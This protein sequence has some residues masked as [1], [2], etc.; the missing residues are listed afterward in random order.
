[1][2][3][4]V[5]GYCFAHLTHLP[6][7]R[8]ALANHC[9]A[10]NLKGTILLSPEGINV[11]LAGPRTG[12]ESAMDLIRSYPGLESFVG[13]ESFSETQP[14]RRMLVRLK[15]E[16][17]SFGVEKANPLHHE[18]PRLSPKDLKRWLDEGKELIL[19]DTRNDYEVELGTFQNAEHFDLKSFRA[20]IPAVEEKRTTWKHK[21]VV[22]FCTGGIRCEKAAPFMKMLGYE[23]VYQLEGGILK[24]FEEV[25]G[26]HWNGDCFVFDQRVAL[27]PELKPSGHGLCF[28][29]QTVLP[30]AGDP[31]PTCSPLNVPHE[32]FDKTSHI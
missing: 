24:Y 15:K 5:S 19:L 10:Q 2:I 21:T 23:D 18:A 16:V 8:E 25:G 31:C 29:C 11:F 3:L 20:F 12:V 13:K 26:E 14:F 27:N 1:M 30:H 17:I 4:N 32:N 7:M 9:K 22:T 28:D 6:K